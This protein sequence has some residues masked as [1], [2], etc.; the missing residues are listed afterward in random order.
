MDAFIL[1]R[2]VD[3]FTPQWWVFCVKET[4]VEPLTRSETRFSLEGKSG[5]EK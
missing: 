1:A 3:S 5:E 4:S 2:I